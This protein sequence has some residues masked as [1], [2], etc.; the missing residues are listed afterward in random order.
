VGIRLE[1]GELIAHKEEVMSFIRKLLLS[2][3]SVRTQLNFTKLFA[4]D[5]SA[6]NCLLLGNEAEYK[7]VIEA[8]EVKIKALSQEVTA[9]R[10]LNM[11]L[12]DEM[13]ATQKRVLPTPTVHSNSSYVNKVI[14]ESNREIMEIKDI[15]EMKDDEIARL[16]EMLEVEQSTSNAKSEE[17]ERLTIQASVAENKKHQDLDNQLEELKNEKQ[18]L[19]RK[20]EQLNQAQQTLKADIAERDKIILNYVDKCKSKAT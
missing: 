4:N 8:Q 2:N 3:E 10:K 15:I 11:E 17:I 20:I 9:L 7:K 14:K 12:T 19:I 18:R 5:G 16:K 13:K 1:Q 6:D